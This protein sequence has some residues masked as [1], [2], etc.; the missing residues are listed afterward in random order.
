MKPFEISL[1]YL[2]KSRLNQELLERMIAAMGGISEEEKEQM[3]AHHELSDWNR[4]KAGGGLG[5]VGV[6]RPYMERYNEDHK[7]EMFPSLRHKENKPDYDEEELNTKYRLKDHEKAMQNLEAGRLD[8]LNLITNRF[9]KDEWDKSP[10]LEQ[11]LAEK[12]RQFKGSDMGQRMLENLKE[13]QRNRKLEQITGVPAPPMPPISDVIHE[14][15]D[16]HYPNDPFLGGTRF[17]GIYPTSRMGGHEQLTGTATGM[18]AEDRALLHHLKGGGKEPLERLQAHGQGETP[19]IG[20]M[21]LQAFEQT[22]PTEMAVPQPGAPALNSY[23][24]WLQEMRDEHQRL[25][26][27][28]SVSQ[29]MGFAPPTCPICSSSSWQEDKC[30]VCSYINPRL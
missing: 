30:N 4:A 7:Q 25:N 2:V 9:G 13:R 17:D 27:D 16:E 21:P 6:T 1:E 22:Y 15:L 5:S 18:T 26:P 14:H 11:E 3:L 28:E 29:Q 23:P 20:D 8:G 24:P 12:V 19:L 10:T